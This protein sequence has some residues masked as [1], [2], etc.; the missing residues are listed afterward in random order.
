MTS[1][2]K[3]T[4]SK[5]RIQPVAT[6]D[7]AASALYVFTTAAALDGSKRSVLNL[8]RY[9]FP[10]DRALPYKPYVSSLKVPS[11]SGSA[12]AYPTVSDSASASARTNTSHCGSGA[13]GVSLSERQIPDLSGGL[14][15]QDGSLPF[16]PSMRPPKSPSCLDSARASLT[17]RDSA[18]ASTRHCGSCGGGLIPSGHQVPEQS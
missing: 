7:A 15:P 3:G 13:G 10:R 9:L 12:R 2:V 6:T 8:R 11:C 4:A 14:I 18:S 16:Y 1:S 5:H 17:A